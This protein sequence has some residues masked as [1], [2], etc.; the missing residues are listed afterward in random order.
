MVGSQKGA[1]SKGC[2]I[3]LIVVGVLII[4]AV[5]ALAVC[6]AYRDKLAKAGVE[7]MVSGVKTE[8]MEHPVE[9]VDTVQ[10][11]AVADGFMERLD[12]AEG[13]DAEKSQELLATVQAVMS[14]KELDADEVGDLMDGM[15][16]YFPDLEALR[17]PMELPDTN[18]IE[19]TT[20]IE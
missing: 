12:A 2:L 20:L 10:F 9:G 19:D 5:I 14:D 8:L 11:N 6:Y 13:F 18:M 17:K 16:A 15:V 3:T 4:L 1:M 7:V